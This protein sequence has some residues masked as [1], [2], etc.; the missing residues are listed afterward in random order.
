MDNTAFMTKKNSKLQLYFFFNLI[1]QITR[2]F[3]FLFSSILTRDPGK[4]TVISR[5]RSGRARQVKFPLRGIRRTSVQIYQGVSDIITS[6]RTVSHCEAK[7]ATES[8]AS[9]LYS[10]CL[11]LLARNGRTQHN[12]RM[13]SYFWSLASSRG[14]RFITGDRSDMPQTPGR[15]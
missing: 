13:T 10:V 4:N 6:E 11:G 1:Q 8:T 2:Y 3:C 14:R 9:R 5:Y 7:T 15:N 12:G